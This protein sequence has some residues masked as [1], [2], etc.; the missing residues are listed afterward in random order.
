MQGHWESPLTW[1]NSAVT[2]Q[3]QSYNRINKQCEV[4]LNVSLLGSV[5]ITLACKYITLFMNVFV[6]C[7][8]MIHSCVCVRRVPEV[9][10]MRWTASTRHLT[11]WFRGH[12]SE[13]TF[14]PSICWA[15]LAAGR[16]K[17]AWAF[18]PNMLIYVDIGKW[19]E[20]VEIL[21][22]KSGR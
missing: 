18:A 4:Y 20:Q 11:R 8:G 2:H 15:R 9:P 10:S 5:C 12:P 16:V 19:T 3:S 1:L 17:L 22:P 7:I 21:A 13:A 6:H 14:Q